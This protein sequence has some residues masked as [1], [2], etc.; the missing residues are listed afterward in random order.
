[1]QKERRL[2]REGDFS[3][4]YKRGKGW[5][6]NS[7]ALKTLP[8]HLEH[9]RFGFSVGKRLGT[10]VVRNKIK[11]RLREAVRLSTVKEGWDVIFIARRGGAEADFHQLRQSVEGLLKR[12]SLLNLDSVP[13]VQKRDNA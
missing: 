10:A 11:R 12:A 5:A 6:D 4:V 1:M 7:L 13:A 2:V 9:S 8:N 3:L